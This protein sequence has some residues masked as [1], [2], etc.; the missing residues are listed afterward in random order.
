MPGSQEETEMK[1]GGLLREGESS[2][3]ENIGG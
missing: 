1:V 3:G 2:K